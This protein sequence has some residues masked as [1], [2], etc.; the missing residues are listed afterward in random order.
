MAKKQWPKLGTI[1]VSENNGEKKTRLILDKD[2]TILYKGEEVKLDEYRMT[3]LKPKE[4]I[5][6]SLSFMLENGHID[7]VSYDKQVN[8]VEEKGIRYEI[9]IPQD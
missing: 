1:R 4:G 8:A 9:L 7:Q 2:V 5:L 6:D 3:F